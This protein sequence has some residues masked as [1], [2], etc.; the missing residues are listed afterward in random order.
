[1]P[2]IGWYCPDGET[3]TLAE[4]YDSCRMGE[5]CLTLPTLML[6]GQER[7]WNGV[8]STTQLIDGTMYVYLKL[9]QDY[10]SDPQD[11]AFMIQGTKHHAE[12]EKVAE[13]LGMPAEIALSGD[14]D[15][16]DLVEFEH[17]VPIL[18]DYKLW[19]SFKIAK[20]LGIVEGGKI[21]SPD[22]AVYK[23][24]GKWGK[25]G[26]PKM[27]NSWIQDPD[28]ADNHEAE[29]QLNRYRV[30]LHDMHGIKIDRMVLQVTVRDGN[31]FVATNRGV[32]KNIYRIPVQK[33][34]DEYVRSFFMHKQYSLAQ[35]MD[36]EA[37]PYP[38][39]PT[40]SWEGIRC[41]R[42]CEVWEH[43]SKGRTI[44]NIGRKN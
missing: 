41:E 17:G 19:G 18:T 33:M 27:V 42:Y 43:C 4:C 25:A 22:G 7:E 15:I 6:M 16:F 34:D 8:A 1:M 39:D 40:E 38:C 32:S 23:S 21:P 13:E 24:S 31:T 36:N 26:S 3:T 35:A 2:L 10:Y 9:T 29:L 20:A 14:R 28:K 44:H 12:L 30:M 5:R 37:V 11:R